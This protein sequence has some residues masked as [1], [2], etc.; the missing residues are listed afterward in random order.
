MRANP[1]PCNSCPYRKD[2]P[3]AIWDKE[4]YEK[5]PDYDAETFTQPIAP[6]LCHHTEGGGETL[7]RG[8]VD[9]HNYE[10]LA[11]RM[12]AVQ[13]RL[14]PEF[15]IGTSTVELYGSGVE[16]LVA[17]LEAM[18]S[19]NEEAKR[20]IASLVKRYKRI[21]DALYAEGEI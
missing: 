15:K 6:F 11:L 12:L 19:P 4:E 8:W 1:N 14:G 21:R 5:L 13:R 17:N 9:V 3:L 2:T 18:E 20:K 16:V 10:L 7:C